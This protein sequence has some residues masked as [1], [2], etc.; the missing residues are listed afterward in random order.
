MGAARAVRLRRADAVVPLRLEPLVPPLLRSDLL[1]HPVLGRLEV[2]R[3]P[4]GSNPSY[5]TRAQLAALRE[6][7]P[8]LTLLLTR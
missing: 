8:E 7:C 4:A 1:D 5:V 6:L 3:M 2:V